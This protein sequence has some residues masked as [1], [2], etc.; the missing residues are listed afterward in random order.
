METC[1][2]NLCANVASSSA[3]NV[4]WILTLPAPV[5]CK[6]AFLNQTYLLLLSAVCSL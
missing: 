2:V 5:K 6:L 3:S 1:S 4:D